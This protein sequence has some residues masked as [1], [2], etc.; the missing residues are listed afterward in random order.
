MTRVMIESA[1]GQGNAGRRSACRPTSSTPRYNALHDS[2][3]YMLLRD[4]TAEA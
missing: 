4:G 1:D 2:I 3:T